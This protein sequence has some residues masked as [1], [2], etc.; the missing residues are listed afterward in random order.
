MLEFLETVT[1]SSELLH[2]NRKLDGIPSI[3]FRIPYRRDLVLAGECYSL[4]DGRKYTDN[5][6]IYRY[7][8]DME[9]MSRKKT[10]H[11]HLLIL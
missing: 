8:L 1:A 9:G 6:G 7:T 2:S 10:S 5:R 4:T 3:L 11:L